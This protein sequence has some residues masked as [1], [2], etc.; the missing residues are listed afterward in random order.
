MHHNGL[1][2]YFASSSLD[3]LM[4]YNIRAEPEHESH[5]ES[6][7]HLSHNLVLSFQSFLVLAENLDIIIAESQKS[8]PYCCNHHQYQVYVA[9]A[10]QEQHRQQYCDDNHNTSHRWCAHLLLSEWVDTGIA[11]CLTYLAL[12]HVLD[13]FLSKPCR[14]HQRQNQ[15]EQRT[16]RDVLPH[17][18]ARDIILF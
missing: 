3:V 1:L 16:E 11:L 13:E 17:V 14:E 15:C 8:K 2:C 18:R 9:S 10:P 6:N 12:A 7:T 4:H 5:D